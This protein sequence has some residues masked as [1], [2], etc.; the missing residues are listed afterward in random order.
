G[1]GCERNAAAIRRRVDGRIRAHRQRDLR[2]QRR[3]AAWRGRLI[4]AGRGDGERPEQEMRCNPSPHVRLRA[5][6]V[7]LASQAPMLTRSWMLR[8]RPNDA[9]LKNAPLSRYCL[10]STFSTNNT[11]PKARVAPPRPTGLLP[12]TD[13]SAAAARQPQGTSEERRDTDQVAAERRRGL[14]PELRR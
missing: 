13:G 7:P 5:G 6:V 8:G 1:V 4:A 10:S 3:A 12:E 2:R 14:H 9:P 11:G